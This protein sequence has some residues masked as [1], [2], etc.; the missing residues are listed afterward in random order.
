MHMTVRN[1]RLQKSC[2]L[3]QDPFPM[4]LSWNKPQKQ[5]SLPKCKPVLFLISRH[6]LSAHSIIIQILLGICLDL[7]WHLFLVSFSFWLSSTADTIWLLG[8]KEVN[9]APVK[10]LSGFPESTSLLTT[11][12]PAEGLLLFKHVNHN[13]SPTPCFLLCYSTYVLKCFC[14]F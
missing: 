2:Q 8:G 4:P 10:T 3:H 11:E 7:R 9:L 12:F 5:S 13:T 1:S 14:L 6:L